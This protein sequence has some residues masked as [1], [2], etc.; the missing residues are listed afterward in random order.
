VEIYYYFSLDKYLNYSSYTKTVPKKAALSETYPN[1]TEHTHPLLILFRAYIYSNISL[2]LY[3]YTQITPPPSLDLGGLRFFQKIA[4]YKSITYK[5][6]LK[7]TL[8][9]K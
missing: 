4:T 6:Y 5:L 3:S 8:S 9:K 1:P 7:F 2:N